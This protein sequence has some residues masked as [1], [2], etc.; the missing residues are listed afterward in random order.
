M[1]NQELQPGDVVKLKSGGPSMTIE[2]IGKYGQLHSS[3]PDRAKCVWFEKNQ[4]K[5][6]Y[7]ELH[8]LSKE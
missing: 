7:F 5:E 8:M 1:A 3:G 2:G 4:Q 6:G